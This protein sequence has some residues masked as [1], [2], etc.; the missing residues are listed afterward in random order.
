MPE[1]ADEP[2]RTARADVSFALLA[3]PTVQAV[4]FLSKLALAWLVT[5]EQYGEAMLAG[6]VLFAVQHVACFGLDEAL[7][8]A[9]RIAPGLWRAMRR[10]QNR[11]GI[12]LALATAALGLVFQLVP[13]EAALGRLLCALAPV[14][15]IANR[16]TLPTALLVRERRFAKVFLVDL[17]AVATFATTTVI[18]AA[19]GLGAWSFVVGWTANA[20]ASLF[21]ATAF[22]REFVPQGED[23]PSPE[24]PAT[25]AFGTELTGAAV[26]SYAVERADSA[27]IGFVLG[28][29]ALGAY[30]LALNLSNVMVNYTASLAERL[31]F[32]TLAAHHR[33]DGLGDAYLRALRIAFV[34]LLPAHVALAIVADPLVRTFFPEG[35]HAAGPLV[36]VL[37]LAAAARCVDLV[38]TAA[39]KATGAGP[40]V[41]RLSALR[42]AALAAALAAS[43]RFGVFPTACAVLGSRVIAC[44]ASLALARSIAPSRERARRRLGGAAVAIVVWLLTFVP[45]ALWLRSALS[46]HASLELIVV[47]LAAAAAWVLARAAFDRFELESELETLTQRVF[48]RDG[49]GPR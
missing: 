37:A 18:G 45:G 13:S 14:V 43:L 8:G 26:L 34:F 21:A 38:A 48:S 32:P 3:H 5:A 40:R 10:F 19:A 27:T 30:E 6:L 16:A 24:W 44:A 17:L 42:V 2:S 47:P 15:W 35:F 9:Q 33:A 23:E 31:I 4:R 46:L 28:R 20:L 29:A 12:G 22:A 25:R 1:P 7:I 39:L 41:L 49:G 11:L 36:A